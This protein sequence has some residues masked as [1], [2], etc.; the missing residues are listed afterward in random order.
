MKLGD[1]YRIALHTIKENKSRSIL[2]VVISTFISV[3][4]MGMMSLAIS[5][6]KNS[7]KLINQAYFSENSIVSVEYQNKR[8]FQVEDH[9]LFNES[10]YHSFIV[11]VDQYSDVVGSVYY[12][13]NLLAS[14][15]FVDPKYPITSGINIVEGRMIA[16]S[17]ARNEVIINKVFYEQT[18]LDNEIEPHTIG[19]VHTLSASFIG[20]N[21]AKKQ[22][23]MTT[24]LH[25]V[26]VGIFEAPEEQP[27]ILNGTKSFIAYQNFIGD[28]GIAFN[29][30]N[31]EIYISSC[32]LYH[33]SKGK[34]NSPTMIINRL[35]SL[36][37]ALNKTLPQ[38]VST[39]MFQGPPIEMLV[40]LSDATSCNVCE[41]FAENKAIRYIVVAAAVFMSI[42]LLLI[43]IG[44]LANSV[45]ISIDCSK[46][47]IGLLKV[48]GMKGNTLRLVVIFESVTLISVGVLLGYLL[49]LALSAPLSILVNM[50]LGFTYSAYLK[51]TTFTASINIP[52]Y[53]LFGALFTFLL[54]TYLFSRTALSKIAKMDPIAVISEVS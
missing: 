37:D 3:L 9:V 21:K 39:E 53:L 51:I 52:I 32:V 46:K 40:H 33:Y 43:S 47:F 45:I 48:L 31:D 1:C 54:F 6:A 24:D 27:V 30:N 10:F 16:A 4:I 38:A 26:V 18:L 19:S 28:I 34:V 8:Q 41:K 11:V 50:I 25:Y 5:F 14:I 35:T 17:D 12:E 13:T 44:S 7:T 29:T 22:T 15:D 36:T 23:T 42:I 49:L 2:T 20:L